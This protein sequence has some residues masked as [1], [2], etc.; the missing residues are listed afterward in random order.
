MMKRVLYI[1]LVLVLTRCGDLEKEF[2]EVHI[3]P[4]NDPIHLKKPVETNADGSLRYTAGFVTGPSCQQEGSVK[5]GQGAGYILRKLED[6]WQVAQT[7]RGVK[8]SDAEQNHFISS[9]AKIRAGEIA[10]YSTKDT[11]RISWEIDWHH[12]V[13]E[14]TPAAPTLV[15]ISYSLMRA[16]TLPFITPIEEWKGAILLRRIAPGVTG[17]RMDNYIT[18]HAS[19]TNSQGAVSDIFTNLN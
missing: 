3:P 4:E 19:C 15:K 18:G 11:H 13:V 5:H 9:P 2:Q 16:D 1:A 6:V 8:W 14:G 17:F 7:G 10:V 12:R